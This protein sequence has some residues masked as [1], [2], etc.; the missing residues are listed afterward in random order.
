MMITARVTPNGVGIEFTSNYAYL[1]KLY[2][3]VD[4]LIERNE[5]T[6]PGLNIDFLM[7]LAYDIRKAYEGNRG[8]S[9]LFQAENTSYE[10]FHNHIIWPTYITQVTMLR[11]LSNQSG[12]H[13][14]LIKSL[15]DC[16]VH[17]LHEVNQS[18]AEYVK[19]WFKTVKIT[20]CYL[21][22]IVVPC[23]SE[24]VTSLST[25]KDRMKAL[26]AFLDFIMPSSSNYTEYTDDLLRESVMNNCSVFDLIAV[27]QNA[28]NEHE[29]EW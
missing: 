7:M 23:S 13:K 17:A 25:Q 15:E 9:K 6:M 18:T 5:Q 20:D 3:A 29:I 21:S 14:R 10:L 1:R 27:Y 28:P 26:P 16:A 12:K 8:T 2:N 4:D 22:Q 19:H 24:F 11:Y